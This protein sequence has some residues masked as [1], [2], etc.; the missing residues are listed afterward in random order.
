MKIH[1]IAGFALLG[2]AS[3]GAAA[4][5]EV[6]IYGRLDGGIQYSKPGTI[7]GVSTP[8]TFGMVSGH[9][10]GSRFGFKGSEKIGGDLKAIYLLEGGIELDTGISA[11]SGRLFGREAFVGLEGSAGTLAMGRMGGLTSGAG[12]F[13]MV[14]FDPFVTAWGLA[15]MKAF[16][17]TNKRLDNAIV[18]ET[19]TKYGVTGSVMHS[20]ATNGEEQADNGLNETYTGV[21]ANYKVGKLLMGL[22]YEELGLKASAK[23]PDEKSLQFG[24]YYDFPSVR[25]YFNYER[26]IDAAVKGAPSGSYS[27]ANSYMVGIKADL[28]GKAGEILASYQFRDVEGFAYKTK[29]IDAGL[30]IFSVGYLYPLSKSTQIYGSYVVAVGT[31][32]Y[33]KDANIAKD[34]GFSSGQVTNFNTQRAEYNSQV[35]TIGLRTRF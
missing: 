25:A 16:S 4:Q 10:N 30:N 24:A 35:L 15:G 31:K 12:T 18:Y 22:Y 23:R 17:F 13:S 28:P 6:T 11:Q 8:G 33:D 14:R 29:T 1:S 3:F 27:D 34:Y 2:A 32:A 7:E 19:P 26:S 21:G 5:S 9:T 20:F